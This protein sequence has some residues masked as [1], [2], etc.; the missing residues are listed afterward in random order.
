M[1]EEEN[2]LRG[3]LEN[4]GDMT[5]LKHFRDFSCKLSAR[6]KEI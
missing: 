2:R 1:Q 4:E 5:Q 6:M 3:M